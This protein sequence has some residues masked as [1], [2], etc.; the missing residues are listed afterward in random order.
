MHYR[1]F[2]E[3]LYD[4]LF[5]AVPLGLLFT[6]YFLVSIGFSDE[7]KTYTALIL[8]LTLIGSVATSLALAV[9]ITVTVLWLAWFRIK[10]LETKEIPGGMSKMSLPT[11]RE[12]VG[13]YFDFRRFDKWYKD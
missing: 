10:A 2:K 13:R 3:F 12:R 11:L 6:L 7:A 4:H 1:D 9:A 8:A 5:I